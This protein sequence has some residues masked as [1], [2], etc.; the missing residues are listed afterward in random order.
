MLVCQSER[1]D[2]GKLRFTKV[3]KPEYPADW[4][5][6]NDFKLLNTFLR[7]KAKFDA[8]YSL[9]ITT[10]SVLN[11]AMSVQNFDAIY[12]P[13]NLD[14]RGRMYYS[15][16]FHPQGND[17]SKGL[18]E[19]AEKKELGEQGCYWLMVHVAN[20]FGHDK[21]TL[22]DRVEWVTKNSLAVREFPTTL[23]NIEY[24]PDT[25]WQAVAASLEW[26]ALRTWVE[27]GNPRETFLSGLCVAF[28][29][30]N[31]GCQHLSALVRDE[32]SGKLVNLCQ[33]AV[34]NDIYERVAN[35]TKITSPTV[36]RFKTESDSDFKTR[37]AVYERCFADWEKIGVSRA[38]AKRPVMTLAYGATQR[39]RLEYIRAALYE[40]DMDANSVRDMAAA[41][42]VK[43]EQVLAE[44][45]AGPLNTMK[46]LQSAADISIKQGKAPLWNTPTG[47]VAS[48]GCRKTEPTRIRVRVAKGKRLQINLFKVKEGEIDTRKARNAIAPGYIHSLDASHMMLVIDAMKCPFANVHDSFGCRAGDAKQLFWTVRMIFSKLYGAGDLLSRFAADMGC[49]D[50]KLPVFGDLDINE[51]QMNEFAFS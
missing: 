34:R 51:V 37:K 50:K 21:L 41:L 8:A 30:T 40:T 20:C 15:G 23:D 33:S 39:S 45:L 4:K 11:Q 27:A 38:M 47:F 49:G 46:W 16:D 43:M 6:A 14:T 9:M 12:F 10:K 2:I 26:D 5:K 31:S 25:V 35:A 42:N 17:V 13:V 18:L 22:D 24:D 7:D 3:Q 32:K 29:A 48:V 44:M 1:H 28:D 19:F 36:V